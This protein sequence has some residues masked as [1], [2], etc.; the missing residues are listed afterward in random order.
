MAIPAFC[1]DGRLPE[2]LHFAAEAE[3]TFR[4]GGATPRRLRLAL[5]LRRWIELA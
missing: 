2:G 1:D 5:R 3:M 4:F